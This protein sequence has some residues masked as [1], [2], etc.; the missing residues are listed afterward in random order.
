MESS[1]QTIT[2]MMDAVTSELRKLFPDVHFES[3][4]GAWFN[5]TPAS[6]NLYRTLIGDEGDDRIHQW[7]IV[8]R[9]DSLVYRFA[10]DCHIM[11]VFTATGVIGETIIFYSDPDLIAKL[12]KLVKD[13]WAK[14]E[15]QAA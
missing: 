11:T 15:P 5:A 12:S 8:Y 9:D 13:D 4:L 10:L 6:A 3:I 1:E 7:N 14:L 2:V